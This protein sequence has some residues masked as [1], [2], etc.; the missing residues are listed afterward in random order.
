MSFHSKYK[1][2]SP[3]WRLINQE[4]EL[5]IPHARM[6]LIFNKTYEDEFVKL[7][8]NGVLTVKAGFRWGA[9]GP[10]IDTKSSREAS[11]F[12]DA[13]Y[14]LSDKGLFEGDDSRKM[15]QIADDLL[16]KICIENIMFKW[17]AKAWLTTLEIFGGFAWESKK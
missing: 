14:Y 3:W 13:I 6:T 11:L 16:Y 7:N 1:K 17:R 5:L 12:H 8:K 10:T 9:S 4:F 2:I 15:R